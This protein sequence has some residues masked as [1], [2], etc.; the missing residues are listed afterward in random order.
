MIGAIIL[1]AIAV[2]VVLLA[3]VGQ[4]SGTRGLLPALTSP[5]PIPMLGEGNSL[6]PVPVTFG[7]LNAD[8]V[9]FLNMPIQ[10]TGG[11]MELDSPACPRYSGPNPQWALVAEEL[12]LDAKG[13]DRVVRILEPGTEMSVQGIWRLYQGPLGCGKGP[14]TGSTWYLQVQRIVQPNPLVGNGTIGPVDIGIVDPA[15]PALISTEIPSATPTATATQP[16]ETATG[17]ATADPIVLTA[18]IEPTSTGAATLVA[19]PSVTPIG[20]PS[21]TEPGAGTAQPSATPGAT[22]T[23]ANGVNPTATPSTPLPPTATT[24]SGGGYPGPATATPAATIDPYP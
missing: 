2:A 8:P 10:V 5:T 1:V 21:T 18:S 17:V 13:Y 9:A 4:T 24:T 22:A 3:V 16:V 19:T 23:N 20:A 7:E 15:F 12:Q 11:F 14:A 6:T